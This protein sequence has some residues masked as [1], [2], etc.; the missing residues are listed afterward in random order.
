MFLSVSVCVSVGVVLIFA[1]RWPSCSDDFIVAAFLHSA[2]N[3]LSRLPAIGLVLAV[4]S[5]EGDVNKKKTKKTKKKK[6]KKRLL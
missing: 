1:G 2:N 6:K 5:E 4:Q 3:L